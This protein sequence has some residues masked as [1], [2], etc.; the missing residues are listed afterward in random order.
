MFHARSM[1]LALAFLGCFVA[2]GGSN[3]P[4]HH[5]DEVVPLNDSEGDKKGAPGVEAA[6]SPEVENAMKAIEAKRFSDAKD[7][8]DKAIAKNPKDAQAHYYL[9]V[10]LSQLGG[11][12]KSAIQSFEEALKLDAKLVDA[13]VNLSA[14]KLEAKDASV[15]LSVSEKGLSVAPKQPELALNRALALEA[16]GKFEEALTAYGE[17]VNVRPDDFTLKVSYAQLLAKAKKK[18]EALAQIAAIKECP[19]PRL[20]T[21]GAI[22]ALGLDSP[23]ECV[24]L[25]DRGLKIQQLPALYVRRGMC[26][27]KLKDVGGAS[28]DYKKAIELD[29]KFAPAH[30]Y[31]AQLVKATDKATACRELNLAVEQGGDQGIGPSAKKERTELGCK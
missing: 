21:M 19:D 27:D 7:L 9:G 1:S 4:A 31:L 30:Y 11:D 20:L 28:A 23:A 13:Y 29:G 3:P 12:M 15:A 18:N 14:L 16:M 2:C 22:V 6:S 5:P 26:R 24:A 25:M 8:L 10:T 17:A